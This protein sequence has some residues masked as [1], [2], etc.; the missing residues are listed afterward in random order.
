MGNVI[1]AAA[2]SRDE[3]ENKHVIIA[4]AAVCNSKCK[5]RAAALK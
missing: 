5:H 4:Y 2:A 3:N 1:A